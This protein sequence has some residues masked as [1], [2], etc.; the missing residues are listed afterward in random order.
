MSI[1][2][3]TYD[4]DDIYNNDNIDYIDFDLSVSKAE[5]D[6]VTEKLKALS[7]IAPE[8][9]HEQKSYNY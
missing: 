7:F 4:T 5:A 2:I 8:Q 3:R 1:I 6:K 9:I